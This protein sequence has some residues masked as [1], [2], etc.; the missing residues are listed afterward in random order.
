[1]MMGKGKKIATMP[2][3][4]AVLRMRTVT[5]SPAQVAQ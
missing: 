1:M 2:A 3:T 5:E 4:T